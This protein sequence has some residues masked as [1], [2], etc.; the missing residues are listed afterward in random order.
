MRSID[1][2]GTIG[3]WQTGYFHLPGHNVTENGSTGYGEVTIT[4]DDLG[5]ID[6]TIEDTYVDSN[7][8]AKNSNMGTDGTLTVGSSSSADQ[9]GL[10]RLNMDDIGLHANS[11]IISANMVMTRDSYS[12]TAEVSYHV[13]ENDMWTENGVTW[14]KYDGTYYWD[15]G[16]RIPSMSVGNFEGDQASSKIETDITVAIQNWIDKNNDAIAAGDS[17]SKT[18]ELMM[19]AS[20]WGIDETT[21]QSLSLIHI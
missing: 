8:V 4:F 9:Y 11:S 3:Q 18:L 14:R 1:S 15:D 10:L 6:K 12:G 5:L 21:T 13:M 19:V 20:T 7:G 17:P 2:A 16:G